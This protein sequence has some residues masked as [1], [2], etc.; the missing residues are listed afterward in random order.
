MANSHFPYGLSVYGV[1]VL[2]GPG[3]IP[4]LKPNENPTKIAAGYAGVQFVCGDTGS[5]ANTGFTPE[6]PLKNLDTAYNRTLGGRNE[7]IFVVGGA[8]SVNFSSAIASAG[9]G[10]VWSKSYT[11]LVGLSASGSSGMRSHV[12]NGASTNLYTPLI[13]VSGNGCLFENIEFFNGG[14][15]ATEAAVCVLVTGSY[16]SFVNCQISGGGHATAAA[17]AATRSLVV[18]GNGTGGGGENTFRHCYIG[19]TTVQRGSTSSEIELKT[20]TPRNWFEDCTIASAASQNGTILVSIDATGI[21]DFVVFRNCLFVN[22]G[23]AQGASILAQAMA[24]NATPGGVVMLHNCLSGGASVSFT[25]FQ[26]TASGP[27]FADN[28]GSATGVLGV[29]A[30]S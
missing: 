14:A 3:V 27:V 11:H 2:P 25:K 21:Q 28:P 4:N 17:N 29:A 19:L 30:T 10:L 20:N 8:S 15:H 6:S 12:S 24:V 16:N 1:P 22:P 5:D 9:V 18:Q 13:T 26:T 23:T 7:I